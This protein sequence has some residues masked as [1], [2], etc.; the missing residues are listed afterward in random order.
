MSLSESEYV[1]LV[2]F[3]INRCIYSCDDEVSVGLVLSALDIILQSEVSS[4]IVLRA[5]CSFSSPGY[6]AWV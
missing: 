3:D 1:V 5:L 2:T 4:K 6:C